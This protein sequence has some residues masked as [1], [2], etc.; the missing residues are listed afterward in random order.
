MAAQELGDHPNERDERGDD[1]D[2][3][4]PRSLVH[5]VLNAADRM[6][7][8]RLSGFQNGRI[9]LQRHDP[10]FE[11]L[12]AGIVLTASGHLI[13]HRFPQYPPASAENKSWPPDSPDWPFFFASISAM[14]AASG[15]PGVY[16][17][18]TSA[19]ACLIFAG[20]PLLSKVRMLYGPSI[21]PSGPKLEK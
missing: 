19:A 5:L 2:E 1:G 11:V 21:P 18:I 8:H 16:R 12:E 3:R 13:V 7:H 9:D 10:V 4:E 6:L 17:C 15:E 20:L 14:A